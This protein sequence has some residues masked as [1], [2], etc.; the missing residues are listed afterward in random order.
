MLSLFMAHRLAL[1]R[2]SMMHPAQQVFV[3]RR[4]TVTN[5]R[6]VLMVLEMP[7]NYLSKDIVVISLDAE[8]AFDKVTIQWF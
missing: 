6:K 2:P 5:V 1:I 3:K 4:L 7:K 8:K